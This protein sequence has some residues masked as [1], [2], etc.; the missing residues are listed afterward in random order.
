MEDPVE[1]REIPEMPD[2]FAPLD[3][4]EKDTAHLNGRIYLAHRS[5][6]MNRSL[7]NC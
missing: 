1:I 4:M 6:R 2:P 5:S 3:E 7:G